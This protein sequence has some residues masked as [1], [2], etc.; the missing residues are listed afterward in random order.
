MKLPIHHVD[1]FAKSVFAGNPAAVV[2]LESWIYDRTLQAIAAE[3][4]VSE[5]AFI[6]PRDGK[7]A[8]WDIRWFTPKIEVPLCG[9]ATLAAGFVVMTELKPRARRVTFSSQAGELVVDKAADKFSV[10]LP[11][12]DATAR[13][14]LPELIAALGATPR[15]LLTTKPKLVAVFGSA[16]EVAALDP[17]FRALAQLPGGQS[18]VATAPGADCDFVSRFFAPASGVDEDPVTG[19]A[20]CI[21]A[22]LWGARLKKDSLF[23]KQISKRGG[24]IWCK[25]AAK[26]VTLTGHVTP[27]LVGEI[28]V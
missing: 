15:S 21:L 11:R 25:V 6:V 22:P 17:D 1:A 12:S 2:P 28:E 26:T 10:T 4:N 7:G 19:S 9:H 5:T 8:A 23:A 27:Y 3:N 20:H 13:Q 24:E 18:V 16:A 14:M